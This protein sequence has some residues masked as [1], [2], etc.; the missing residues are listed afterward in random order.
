MKSVDYEITPYRTIH[1]TGVIALWQKVFTGG[2]AWNDPASDIE[3]K[4]AVQRNLFLVAVAGE[5][6]VGTVMGGY[7]G[8]RG[9]IY[10][11]AVAPDR[12]NHGIGTALVRR[13]EA[14][15]TDIGCPKVNLQVR[16]TNHEVV[17]FYRKLGYRLEERVSMGKLL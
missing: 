1:E 4:M 5:A 16:S 17:E 13:I 11:L 3:R 8:H 14:S 9:W 6:V 10:Y 2:P 7:D 12:R 15:L